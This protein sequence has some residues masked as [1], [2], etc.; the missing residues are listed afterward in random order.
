RQRV[1]DATPS[2]FRFDDVFLDSRKGRVVARE[3]CLGPRLIA[4]R[5]LGRNDKGLAYE[6]DASSC[7]ASGVSRALQSRA[8]RR[9]QRL[10][11][12]VGWTK[13]PFLPL[14]RVGQK[15][16]ESLRTEPTRSGVLDR[17]PGLS[18]SR[19]HTRPRGA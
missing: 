14:A 2:P 6:W 3:L 5:T 15:I 8:R 17:S 19:L 18:F 12:D 9:R 13:V 16:K 7:P 11:R 1:V 10:Q 4:A